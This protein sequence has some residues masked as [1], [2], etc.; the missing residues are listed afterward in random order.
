MKYLLKLLAPPGDPVVLDPF[1]GS[2]TT[3][4]AAEMLGIRSIGIEKSEEYFE[5]A[6]RRLESEIQMEFNNL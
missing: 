5:I 3:C 4:L 6:K 1:M 2:G